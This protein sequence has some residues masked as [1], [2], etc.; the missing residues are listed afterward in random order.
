MFYPSYNS[1]VKKV[2]NLML[3]NVLIISFSGLVIFSKDFLN[4]LD[5]PRLIG[6]LLTAVIDMSLTRLGLPF[7]YMELARYAVA[8]VGNIEAKVACA[9]FTDKEDG[10]VFAKLMAKEILD[11]FVK[12][13]GK[14]SMNGVVISS[15]EF[16]S[17]NGKI[18]ECFRSAIRPALETLTH[19]GVLLSFL[20][21]GDYLICSSA[22][23]DRVAI[24]SNLQALLGFAAE[25][26]SNSGEEFRQMIL[27]NRTTRTY[28]LRMDRA[29]L[30][31]VC[32]RNVASSVVEKVITPAY[33]LLAKSMVFL[34]FLKL[35]S[36][37]FAN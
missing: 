8:M 25:F 3:H 18:A 14:S 19:R 2:T 20:T 31:V 37:A 12:S 11:S 23:V 15:N 21:S 26:M 29:T 9:V 5:Q 13:Y 17:F 34:S 7:S 16:G 10:S 30:V 22:E 35:C 32:R 1:S 24:M 6:G 33:I 4:I 36:S 28:L 27:S